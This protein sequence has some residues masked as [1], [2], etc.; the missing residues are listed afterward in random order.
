MQESYKYVENN[1]ASKNIIKWVTSK[2]DAI[3]MSDES[4]MIDT[5]NFKSIYL[6]S[7]LSQ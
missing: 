6:G 2:I 1:V 5:N 3:N 4:Y 7:L